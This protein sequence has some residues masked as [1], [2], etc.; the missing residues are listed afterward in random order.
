MFKSYNGPISLFR[1]S[2]E[3]ILGDNKDGLDDPKVFYKE[4][5]Q[6]PNIDDD[7][8]HNDESYREDIQ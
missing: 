5:I 6:E 7:D 1:P 4:H 8:N 3:E 2:N